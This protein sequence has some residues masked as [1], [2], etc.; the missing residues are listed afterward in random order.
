[1]DVEGADDDA[2]SDPFPDLGECS[3]KQQGVI[4]PGVADNT[5]RWPLDEALV[6]EALVTLPG[7]GYFTRRCDPPGAE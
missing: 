1:M 3:D 6:D 5:G 7:A 4:P 2:D